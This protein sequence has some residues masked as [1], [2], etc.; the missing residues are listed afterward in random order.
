LICLARKIFGLKQAGYVGRQRCTFERGEY[1][2][3]GWF[4]QQVT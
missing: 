2:Q 3:F 4:A 1:R